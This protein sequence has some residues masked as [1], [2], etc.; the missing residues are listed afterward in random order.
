MRDKSEYQQPLETQNRIKKYIN[1]YPELFTV[2]S[3]IGGHCG[4]LL[5]RII[6]G[7][8]SRWF[9]K[10]HMAMSRENWRNC[11]PLDWPRNTE[12][13]LIYEMYGWEKAKENRTWSSYFKENHLASAHVGINNIEY[14]SEASFV[15][16][17]KEAKQLNKKILI[18]SHNLDI[19][20]EL[21]N[22]D[23]IRVYGSLQD[24]IKPPSNRKYKYFLRNNAQV[25]PIEVNNVYN[26]NIGKLISRNYNTFINEY[27]DLCNKFG[28]Y[29]N[30]NNV[31]AYILMWIERMDRV[32]NDM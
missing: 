9:W 4:N 30:T 20:K 22:V 7:T 26:I 28:M 25:M 10:K 27:L 12:G 23:I 11:K 31:R 13:Y 17:V 16:F 1:T 3:V 24:I 2:I 32:S 18:R 6:A 14:I 21:S 15:V 5:L 8:D 29:P 19:H